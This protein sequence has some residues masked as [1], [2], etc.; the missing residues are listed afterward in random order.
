MAGSTNGPVA[1]WHLILRT[2][3]GNVF[4]LGR[5]T[6]EATV[7]IADAINQGDWRYVIEFANDVPW[8]PEW[9]N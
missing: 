7:L 5:W 1:E 4:P 3:F 2:G 9:S 8:D 6:H